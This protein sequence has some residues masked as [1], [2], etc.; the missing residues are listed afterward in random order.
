MMARWV[1][2]NDLVTS[3][4]LLLTATDRYP[5]AARLWS[6]GEPSSPAVAALINAGAAIGM[7]YYDRFAGFLA[8]NGIPTL[9]YDYRGIGKSRPTRL[10]GFVASVEDW[11]SKDC[12]AVIGWLAER[13]PGAKRIV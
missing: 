12:A 9:I 1:I 13:F 6:T 5:L 3:T 8:S 7:P 10:R 4:D 11:G 2:L